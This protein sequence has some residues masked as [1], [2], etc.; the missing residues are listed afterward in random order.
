MK[1]Q[2]TKTMGHSES[3]AEGKIIYVYMYDY[4]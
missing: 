1:L 2:Q 4:I 3:S